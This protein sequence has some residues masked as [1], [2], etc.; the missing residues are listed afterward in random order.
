MS[1]VRGTPSAPRF[2][3]DPDATDLF[4][5]D[6]DMQWN[7]EAIVN[8]VALPDLVV[9][10]SYPTKNNWGSWTSQPIFQEDEATKKRHPLGRVLP[11]GS[12]LIHADFLAAGFMRLKR[13]ALEKYRDHYPEHRYRE[14][15]AD[16]SN[17]DR[18]YIEYFASIR[19]NGLLYG[20]DMMFSKRLK[21]MGM[22]MFI[23]TNVNMGHYGVKGWSGNYHAFLKGNGKKQDENVEA[24]H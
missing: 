6:S 16:P 17:P 12:A 10:G 7:A 24:I 1:T 14:P 19:Q 18:E 4:F 15:C 23:Y 2:L 20:E 5:I 8:M 3:E 21:E 13:E 22:D 9:G 11:D